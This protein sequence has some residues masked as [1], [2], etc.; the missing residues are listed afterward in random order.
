MSEGVESANA[1]L[2]TSDAD[3]L[4]ESMAVPELAIHSVIA[5]CKDMYLEKLQEAL[6]A[7]KSQGNQHRQLDVHTHCTL[8]LS[9]IVNNFLCNYKP[10][11]YFL[12]YNVHIKIYHSILRRIP[13]FLPCICTCICVLLQD[14]S[15]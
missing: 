14:F 3:K 10:C 4:L 12:E 6:E 15:K 11:K 8:G 9:G 2:D 5:D 13:K 1:A 7:K